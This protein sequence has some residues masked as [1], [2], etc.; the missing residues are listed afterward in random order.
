MATR[1]S[2][3]IRGASSAIGI[4]I[5]LLALV[6]VSRAE[7][8][9]AAGTHASRGPRSGATAT[10]ATVT[11]TSSSGQI[12]PAAYTESQVQ[13]IAEPIPGGGTP[14][15]PAALAQARVEG[16]VLAEFVVDTTGRIELDSFRAVESTNPIFT[17]AVRS[18]LPAL[19]YRPATIDGKPV[20]QIVQQP[21]VFSLDQ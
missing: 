5:A 11:T 12:G 17:E 6:G 2:S 8:Q 10:T 4:L 13:E 16:R 7:A 14:G 21:F 20:R 1:L 19:R 3:G 9:Q 15:Y 18:A